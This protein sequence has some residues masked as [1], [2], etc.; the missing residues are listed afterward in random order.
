M[1]QIQTYSLSLY[2]P[3]SDNHGCS[4]IIRV[5]SAWCRCF[6]QC[7]KLKESI[8]RKKKGRYAN[9][10]PTY[11]GGARAMVLEHR[12]SSCCGTMSSSELPYKSKRAPAGAG[13]LLVYYATPG[14]FLVLFRTSAGSR[15]EPFT[16]PAISCA[17]T[18]AG[19]G[20]AGFA[21]TP[22]MVQ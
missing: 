13:A 9:G 3:S 10:I 5:T 17:S 22:W 16:L 20:S 21:A 14:I 15:P 2:I 18:S 1:L 11:F 4:V 8:S 19:S 6:S 12:R 7:G